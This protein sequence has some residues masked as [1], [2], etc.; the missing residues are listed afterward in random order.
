[1]FVFKKIICIIVLYLKLE[2][3]LELKIEVF[4]CLFEN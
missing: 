3:L 4:E 2:A 1:M